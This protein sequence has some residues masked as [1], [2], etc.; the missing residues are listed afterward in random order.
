MT[1]DEPFLD[2]TAQFADEAQAGHWETEW[3]NLRARMRTNPFVIL[4]GF[5]SLVGRLTLERDGRT[6]RVHV[7]ATHDETVRL[8]GVA[9]RLL[10]G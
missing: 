6:I 7:S 4:G 9:V 3:P 8:M 5:S 1:G 2:L 10:G